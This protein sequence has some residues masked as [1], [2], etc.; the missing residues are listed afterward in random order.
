[1]TPP[2]AVVVMGVS[3]CGKTTL[4]LALAARLGRPFRDGDDLHPA[5]NRAKMAAG[6]ALG[7]ADRA[8]WLQAIATE[9]ATRP[10]VILACSAL[11][12][13]YRDQIRSA[14]AVRFLWLDAP[15]AVIA[16]RVQ[17][18]Q[19]HFMPP[20]LLQSQFDTLEPPGPDED[21]LRLDARVPVVRLVDLA[22][23]WLGRSAPA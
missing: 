12:R 6:R 19:G 21:A 20:A 15:F 23:G 10:G 5:E 18:R 8:P 1:M 2:A 9:I 17:A 13:S 22:T 7:D 11:R 16:A 3:G 4:A 14:G